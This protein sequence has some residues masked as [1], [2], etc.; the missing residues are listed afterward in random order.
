M[1]RCPG[2]QPRGTGAKLVSSLTRVVR[3]YVIANILWLT[4]SSS[5]AGPEISKSASMLRWRVMGRGAEWRCDIC[6]TRR[7]KLPQGHSSAAK[8]P[9]S[10]APFPASLEANSSRGIK[11]LQFEARR[12]EG[13][14]RDEAVQ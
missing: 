13:H 3:R 5:S 10:F 12:R 1:R 4:W 14:E 2:R 7:Q 6:H 8:A 9:P 11:H